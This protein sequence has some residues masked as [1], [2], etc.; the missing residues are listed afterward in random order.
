MSSPRNS[1]LGTVCSVFEYSMR[2]DTNLLSTVKMYR[3]PASPSRRAQWEAA[4]QR[5]NWKAN[6]KSAL[7]NKHFIT[8]KLSKDSQYTDYVQ[9]MFSCMEDESS[10]SS[11]N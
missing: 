6:P 1:K 7:C 5:K 2:S 11:V 3:F 9:R 4:L 10:S 8:G